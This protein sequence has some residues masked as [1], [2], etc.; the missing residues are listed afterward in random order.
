[1][2]LSSSKNPNLPPPPPPLKKLP[3]ATKRA[4][5]PPDIEP[6][7][8]M[9]LDDATGVVGGSKIDVGTP[10]EIRLDVGNAATGVV[11]G[12]AVDVVTPSK[13]AEASATRTNNMDDDLRV[14]RVGKMDDSFR[15][16]RI[17]KIDGD[18]IGINIDEHVVDSNENKKIS[19]RNN[20]YAGKKVINNN[21]EDDNNL[22]PDDECSA[23]T[24]RRNIFDI[25][26]A[27][28]NVAPSRCVPPSSTTTKASEDVVVKGT[29]KMILQESTTMVAMQD[30]VVVGSCPATPELPTQ[31]HEPAPS[32]IQVDATATSSRSNRPIVELLH[33]NAIASSSS[34]RPVDLLHVDATTTSPNRPVDELHHVE[35]VPSIPVEN[36]PLHGR[37]PAL[38]PM[39]VD[40]RDSEQ[41]PLSSVVQEQPGDVRLRPAVAQEQ[42]EDPQP[43]VRSTSRRSFSSRSSTT[44]SSSISSSSSRSRSP[45]SPSRRSRRSPSPQ[46]PK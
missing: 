21:L 8:R 15:I 28:S 9:R 5:R 41:V 42:V 16:A 36:E 44:S 2:S 33:A 39:P 18:L 27:L 37:E 25:N 34:N 10:S 20:I 31:N 7:K 3:S 13:N 26:D 40:D 30:T 6:R 35:P 24:N 46:G 1:M 11:R 32:P 22:E 4:A 12:N 43:Q 17:G 29:N 45:R 19:I 38:T 14:A 23:G